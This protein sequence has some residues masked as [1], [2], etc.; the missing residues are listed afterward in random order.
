LS[1]VLRLNE[2]LYPI[3]VDLEQEDTCISH[4]EE[5]TCISYEEEDTITSYEEAYAHILV[6]PGQ[7]EEGRRGQEGGLGYSFFLEG[8]HYWVRS[9]CVTLLFLEGRGWKGLELR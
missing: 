9:P 4:E 7:E 8:R 3:L 2:F 1:A 6:N 5:D